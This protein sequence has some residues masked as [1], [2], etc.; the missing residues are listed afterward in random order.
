MK[1]KGINLAD[2]PEWKL[3]EYMKPSSFQ[4]QSACTT[5]KDTLAFFRLDMPNDSDDEKT[6]DDLQKRIASTVKLL[7]MVDR[8]AVGVKKISRSRSPLVAAKLSTSRPSRLF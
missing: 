6:V 2:I 4:I 8:K 3:T 5:T 1:E 7:E